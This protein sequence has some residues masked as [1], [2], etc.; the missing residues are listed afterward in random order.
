MKQINIENLRMKVNVLDELLNRESLPAEELSR[1]L[2]RIRK[3][4]NK[5][6]TV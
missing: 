3:N 5:Y 1:D 2:K 4:L 6:F